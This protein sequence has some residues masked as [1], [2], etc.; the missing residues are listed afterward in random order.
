MNKQ[1]G[2]KGMTAIFTA[3]LVAA[4]FVGGLGGY[5]AAKAEGTGAG[6][7]QQTVAL[8]I[9]RGDDGADFVGREPFRWLPVLTAYTRRFRSDL[10]SRSN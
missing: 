5:A 10:Y 4:L 9:G 1:T 8:A 7:Q 3:A 6:T 2:S